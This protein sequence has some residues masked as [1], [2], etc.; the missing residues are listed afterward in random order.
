MVLANFQVEDKLRKARFFQETFLLANIN[1][2]VVLGMLFHTL[3]NTDVEFVEK[4]LT[5]RSYTTAGSTN[6]QV[7]RTY[8]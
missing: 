2:E 8:Q 7:S 4:K 5:W 3:S 6:Y 1:A